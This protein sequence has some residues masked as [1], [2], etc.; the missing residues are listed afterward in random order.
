M[1]SE[2]I[3]HKR[4]S[5]LDMLGF[6]ASTICAIHCALLPVILLFLPLLGL[7]FI[8]NPAIE[9]TLIG[10]SLIIGLYTLRNGYLKH[11]GKLYP[12]VLFI[13]GL[14][15]IVLG[16]F[17]IGHDLHEGKIDEITFLSVLGAVIIP[18][19]AVLIAVA[20]YKNR[21]MCLSCT[22]DHTKEHDSH[23]HSHEGAHIYHHHELMDQSEASNLT[24]SDAV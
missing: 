6:S 18:V 23:L 3:E 11:H 17:T 16:H 15:I 21:K 20:H 8:T 5:R 4:I 1:Q 22:H 7:E 19:G 24:P 2:Q 10:V 14:S 9:I 12:T 13:L